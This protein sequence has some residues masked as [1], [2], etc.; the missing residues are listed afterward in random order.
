MLAIALTIPALLAGA[1]TDERP[2]VLLIMSDQHNP[3]YLGC[4]GHPLLRTP[5]LDRLAREGARF[6]AAYSNAPVCAPARAATFFGRY[7][8]ELGLLNNGFELQTDDRHMAQHL[9]AAGYTTGM[10]GKSHILPNGLE[11]GAFDCSYE[12]SAGVISAGAERSGY[13]RYLKRLFVE[14]PELFP[15]GRWRSFSTHGH[16]DYYFADIDNLRGTSRIPAEHYGASL[17]TERAIRFI[18]EAVTG[19]DPFFLFA[20][21]FIPHHPYYPPAPYERMFDPDDVEL[22]PNFAARTMRLGASTPQYTEREWREIIA[23]YCGLV[24]LLDDQVGALVE[25]LEHHGVLDDTLV[26]FVADHGDMMGEFQSL[27]KGRLEDASARVPLILRYGDEIE[28]GLVV[29]EPV[30][31]VDIFA[32]VL[33]AAQV[34]PPIRMRGRSLLGLARGD[35]ETWK[36]HV[37]CSVQ[38]LVGS[39]GMC[40]RDERYKFALQGSRWAEPEMR[41]HLFDM[42]AD[43]W[44]MNDLAG[45]P[46][47]AETQAR[48]EGVLRAWWTEQ[49]A[50]EPA[51]T[52]ELLE[53]EH[54]SRNVRASA[55]SSAPAPDELSNLRTVTRA[56]M[57]RFEQYRE[58]RARMLER[59]ES[60]RAKGSTAWA[61][62]ESRRATIRTELERMTRIW[63]FELE[64]AL[65]QA[66]AQERLEE[67]LPELGRLSFDVLREWTAIGGSDAVY[68]ELEHNAAV[69]R[70]LATLD[71]VV[72]RRAFLDVLTARLSATPDVSAEEARARAA[73]WERL[74]DWTAPVEER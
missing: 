47:M 52:T 15:D 30:E 2:N 13:A 35:A 40:V 61:R 56:L 27:F 42:H 7:P 48:L 16:N 57:E 49:R 29:D 51:A 63:R 18:D 62:A 50:L 69:C 44:E 3:R 12:L 1:T 19:E 41:A 67:L 25:R 26:I 37:F 36:E 43:P 46:E 70:A 8:T 64:L 55:G 33:A 38:G 72:A 73:K 24:V 58:R 14:R 65:E 71:D 10:S 23:L 53:L 5:H 31:Q 22:P 21:Y 39:L 74:F 60:A 17:I 11:R 34:E 6:T 54:R 45:R 32:T 66:E 20:S 9:A 59:I 28:H 68:A 4:A